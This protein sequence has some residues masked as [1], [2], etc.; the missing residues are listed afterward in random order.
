V[1]SALEV[2]EDAICDFPFDDKGSKANALAAIL[3]P[4]VRPAIEGPTPLALFDATA[5]GTGKSLLA[6]IVSIIAT[7]REGAMMTVPKNRDEWRKKITSVL[8]ASPPVVV[9]DNVS[10]RLDADELMS[11]LSAETWSDRLLGLSKQITIPIRCAWIVT[12]NNVQLEGQMVRRSYWVRM[13]AKLARPEDREEFKHPFLKRHVK[14]QR[15]DLLAALLTLARS[16][17]VNGKQPPDVKPL[18]GFE[19]WTIV[20]GGILQ[21]AGVKGFLANRDQLHQQSDDETQ[22]WE[23]LL[24]QLATVFKGNPFTTASILAQMQLHPDLNETIEA[25]FSDAIKDQPTLKQRIAKNFKKLLGR[26]FG[27]NDGQQFW[28]EQA[29]TQH[30][31]ARWTVRSS[32]IQNV[33]TMPMLEA[34]RRDPLFGSHFGQ[35]QQEPFPL[36]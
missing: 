36:S 17:F 26:R 20:I 30:R 32:P 27:E 3:T 19:S 25:L 22:F 2:V 28:L 24:S 9:F 33:K 6:E 18:G 8:L 12:A 10:N 4:I 13:D 7:G 5:P 31:L 1:Q 23:S 21:N 11:V 35:S 34:V 16:W 14:E 29:G 15:G